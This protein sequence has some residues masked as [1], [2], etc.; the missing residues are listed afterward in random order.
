MAGRDIDYNHD[1]DAPQAGDGWI[2]IVLGV[3]LLILLVVWFV[4]RL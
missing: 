3:P 2:T 1:T 4:S